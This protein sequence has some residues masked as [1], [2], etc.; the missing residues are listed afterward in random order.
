MITVRI[1]ISARKTKVYQ[2]PQVPRVDDTLWLSDDTVAKVYSVRW[3]LDDTTLSC[4][5]VYAHKV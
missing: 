1:I 4:V 3:V 2:L 5:Q